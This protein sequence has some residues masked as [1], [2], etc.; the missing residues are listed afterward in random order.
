M[1]QKKNWTKYFQNLL[2]DLKG[3]QESEGPQSKELRLEESHG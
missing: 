3:Q 1:G 2:E